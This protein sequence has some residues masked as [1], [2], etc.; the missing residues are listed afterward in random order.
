[1][2]F[3]TSFLLLPQSTHLV[4]LNQRLQAAIAP[5]LLEPDLLAWTNIISLLPPVV[6]Q[7]LEL[8]T[9][10]AQPKRNALPL[11]V[12][13]RKRDRHIGPSILSQMM[14]LKLVRVMMSSFL[15]STDP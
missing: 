8:T 7:G 9:V 12:R 6:Y 1:M 14:V 4:R 2:F 5:T 10:G 15:L 3:E 11:A 13:F